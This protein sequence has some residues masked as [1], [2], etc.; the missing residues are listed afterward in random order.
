MLARLTAQNAEAQAGLPA[1]LEEQAREARGRGDEDLAKL[2]EQ[3]IAAARQVHP[4]T[5]PPQVPRRDL[6]QRVDEILTDL[7][8]QLID[9]ALRTNPP[10]VV[11]SVADQLLR[12]PDATDD[13]RRFLRVLRVARPAIAAARLEG[14]ERGMTARRGA[15]RLAIISHG[16]RILGRPERADQ[17]EARARSWAAANPGVTGGY[18]TAL[19]RLYLSQGRT[20][21]ARALGAFPPEDLLLSDL[22]AGIGLANLDSYLSAADEGARNA[23]LSSCPHLVQEARRFAE[24]PRCIAARERFAEP[25]MQYATAA[26]ALQSA[27]LIAQLG[28]AATAR[29][30]LDQGLRAIT[31]AIAADPKVAELPAVISP[32][33][34]VAI[35]KAELRADGR[36]PRSPSP[37]QP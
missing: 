9:A 22:K 34:L 20:E 6:D 27:T 8:D 17:I 15:E 36:L 23:L 4:P 18:A 33:T 11:R 13:P 24:T 31:T 12:A 19:G 2:V 26:S 10:D 14:L 3:Q 35:A 25:R 29:I 5:A 1:F 32:A 28:D 7:H 30:L 21:A 16:W 37:P